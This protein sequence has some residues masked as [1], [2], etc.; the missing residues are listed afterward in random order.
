[1]RSC[2]WYSIRSRTP[3]FISRTTSQGQRQIRPIV[4]DVAA[5]FGGLCPEPPYERARP[6]LELNAIGAVSAC[7]RP[8]QG[9]VES[10]MV[11]V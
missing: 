11:V 1:M 2:A 6:R 4:F 7:P 3:G 10:S 5:P 9:Q 8:P